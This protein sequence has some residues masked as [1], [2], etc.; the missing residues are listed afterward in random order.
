MIRFT[1]PFNLTGSPAITVPCGH[2]ADGLP[3][4]L[5]LAAAP[6]E[7]ELLCFAAAGYEAVSPERTRRPAL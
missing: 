1:G 3:V 2:D 6:Y 5:Q 4:G 7:E